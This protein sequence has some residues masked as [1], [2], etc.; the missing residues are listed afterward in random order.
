MPL[1]G[2]LSDRVGRRPVFVVSSLAALVLAVPCFN[3]MNAGGLTAVGMQIVLGLIES[4]LM[5]VAF[6][7]MAE[8]FPT[9]VRYTGVALGFNIGGVVA[10]GT[11]PLICTWL[12]S[13][14]GSSIAPA[15][16]LIGT[17]VVTLF[18]AFTLKETA[19]SALKP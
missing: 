6:S 18:S 10:G 7:T 19:G 17:A 1:F 5:G 15:Y 12:V 2:A 8:L 3:L 16:F 9:R 11:A 14:T 13:V 4:A